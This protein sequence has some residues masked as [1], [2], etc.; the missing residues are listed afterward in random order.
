MSVEFDYTAAGISLPIK[1]TQRSIEFVDKEVRDYNAA[2]THFLGETETPLAEG[3][4]ETE[5]LIDGETHTAQNGDMVVWINKEFIFSEKS[6]K[7]HEIGDTSDLGD[8]AVETYAYINYTP[9]GTVTDPGISL[10]VNENVYV[11]NSSEDAGEVIAGVPDSM[12]MSVD[13]NGVLDISF[14]QST[15][16]VVNLPHFTKQN[17][18]TSVSEITPA[19][20]TGI[21][22][23]LEAR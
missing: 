13:E 12:S 22:S 3:S 16:T 15:P 7:W 2:G 4:Y 14:T 23:N 9:E 19:S 18:A 17:V 10:N 5:I 1:G 6:G 11:V 20:F 8:L 21:T